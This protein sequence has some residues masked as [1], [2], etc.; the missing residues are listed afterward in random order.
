MTG[1]SSAVTF[2]GRRTVSA[3]RTHRHQWLFYIQEPMDKEEFRRQLIAA[4][5][6]RKL[7][8]HDLG[9]M[10]D[11]EQS[12]VTQ[13]ETGKTTPARERV[14][15][16]EYA[17][18]LPQGTLAQFLGFGPARGTPVTFRQV[19]VTDA[20]LAD[21]RLTPHQRQ[22]LIALYRELTSMARRRSR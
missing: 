7:S 15:A 3:N 19:T 4:R 14:F 1:I 12:A 20:I 5:K 9:R 2:G 18:G 22:L 11:V 17:L 16:I 13:W 21:E 10:V 6:A 8:Q